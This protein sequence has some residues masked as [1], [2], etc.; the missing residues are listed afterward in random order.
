M[1]GPTY[2]NNLDYDQHYS[3]NLPTKNLSY[4][5]N[6][7]FL[8]FQMVSDTALTLKELWKEHYN[9]L[10]HCP[11]KDTEIYLEENVA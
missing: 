11:S 10:D 2:L 8:Y 6:A 9:A 1:T 4:D 5:Q 7:G 3:F